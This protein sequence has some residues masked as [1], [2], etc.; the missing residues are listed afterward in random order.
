MM[1]HMQAIIILHSEQ[2]TI[3]VGK[4]SAYP[5]AVVAYA[6]VFGFLF[7]VIANLYYVF[8]GQLDQFL[9]PYHVSQ[10]TPVIN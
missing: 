2:L 3:I 5:M 6:Y 1:L 8:T 4:W 7:M 9:I 10:W